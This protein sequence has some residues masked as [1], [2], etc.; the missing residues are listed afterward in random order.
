MAKEIGQVFGGIGDAVSGVLKGVGDA[1]NGAVK[2]VGT[3]AKQIWD[4]DV[5][6]AIII[7]GA[8]YFGGAALAGGWSSVGAGGSFFSG[9]GAGV[10]SAA[11]SVAL[12]WETSTLGPLGSAWTEAGM[13]GAEIGASQAATAAA[14]G[15]GVA[16]PTAGLG[17]APG[18]PAASAAGSSAGYGTAGAGAGAGLGADQAAFG[19]NQSAALNGASIVP[20]AAPAITSSLPPA[21]PQPWYSQALDYITPQSDLAKYGL[22]SGATQIAGGIIQGMGQ[23]QAAQEQREY[24]AQQLKNAQDLRN[25]NMAGELWAPG[26]YAAPVAATQPAGL[27]R[28]YMP[29]TAVGAPGYVP[30]SQFAQMYG[31]LPPGYGAVQSVMG[32]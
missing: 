26:Q 5:G 14:L 9:M 15:R 13:A 21:A 20:E 4:S 1:V 30:G 12:A 19:L 28:R 29:R 3:L 32:G 23:D 18:A 31:Q 24:E 10:S 16:T 11:N 25:A 6:K 8:I 17:G 7:A 22:I 27:A 2:G